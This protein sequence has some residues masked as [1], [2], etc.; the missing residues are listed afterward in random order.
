VKKS[1]SHSRALVPGTSAKAKLF[2]ET[3]YPLVCERE[4]LAGSRYPS[5]APRYCPLRQRRQLYLLQS[6]S[7]SGPRCRDQRHTLILGASETP[8]IR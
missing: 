2:E 8:R 5:R 6:C 7:P 3:T 1:E 4:N